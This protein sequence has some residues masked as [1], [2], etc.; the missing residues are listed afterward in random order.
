MKLIKETHL[1]YLFEDKGSYYLANW[2]Y[3]GGCESIY[4]NEISEDL[5]NAILNENKLENVS[6]L[7]EGEMESILEEI[8]Y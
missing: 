8:M 2:G 5:Y 4:A 1:G 3:D 7:D 6:R